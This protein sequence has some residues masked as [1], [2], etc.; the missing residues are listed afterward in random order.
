ML[1]VARAV[2]SSHTFKDLCDMM[3]AN[4]LPALEQALN[5]GADINM[6]D[7]EVDSSNLAV[8]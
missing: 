4:N 3:N 1:R 6:G 2:M 8:N 5:E 7:D